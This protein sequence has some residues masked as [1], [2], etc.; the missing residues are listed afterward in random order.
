MEPSLTIHRP[1]RKTVEW[2]VSQFAEREQVD[3]RTVRRWIYKGAVQVRK[4]PGGGIRV[5]T[6]LDS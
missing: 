4:T 2:T 1:G 3:E 5:V 6:K